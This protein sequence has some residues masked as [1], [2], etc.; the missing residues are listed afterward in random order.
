MTPM[1][2]GKITIPRIKY[3]YGGSREWYYDDDEE[4]DDRVHGYGDVEVDAVVETTN[5]Y[6]I[7]TAPHGMDWVIV[8]VSSLLVC[9][10]PFILYRK[11]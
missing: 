9:A 2:P 5:E 10:L 4:K 11:N 7:R 6:H 8:G 3:T 1:F